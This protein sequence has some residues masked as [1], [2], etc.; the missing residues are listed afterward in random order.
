M[1]H[2]K[3]KNIKIENMAIW[4]LKGKAFERVVKAGYFPPL[5]QQTGSIG[6]NQS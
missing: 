2:L 3:I 4:P 6:R 1:V 5:M